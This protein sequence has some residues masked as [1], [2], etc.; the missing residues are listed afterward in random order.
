MPFIS[1]CYQEGLKLIDYGSGDCTKSS[2]KALANFT[3][4][5]YDYNTK[6]HDELSA[7]GNALLPIIPSLKHLYG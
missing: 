4:A 3:I 5:V 1:E 2:L 7:S 6:M